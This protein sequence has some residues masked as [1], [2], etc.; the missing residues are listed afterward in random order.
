MNNLFKL[1]VQEKDPKKL[2]PFLLKNGFSHQALNNA[3]HHHGMILVNHK[4]R[5]T[6]FNLK[7]GDEVLFISGEEKKNVFLKPS[8]KPVSIVLE[9]PNY[10]VVNKTAGVLSIPSRYEDDDAVVNRLLGYFAKKNEHNLKPHVVTRLD[11]DTSGLVLVGKNSIAHARFSKINKAKFVKK[12]HAIVHGNFAPNQLT[13]LI[14][15]PLGKKGTGVKRVVIEG[16]KPAQTEYQVL[17]QVAGASLVELRLLTGRTH[18][19]RVH[20]AYLGHP[21]YGDPLYGVQDNFSRQALN[22]FY[23]DFPD[24]FDQQKHKKI[25]LEDPADMQ[26]LWQTLINKEF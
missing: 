19:I 11:R 21:L 10:L 15:Q 25:E 17:D 24:P 4:R 3:K 14:D 22:C 7:T 18:Q 9:T 20:M 23:L 13:G 16:G 2:G 6:S 26:N 1:T 12:Y 8:S 5:Y